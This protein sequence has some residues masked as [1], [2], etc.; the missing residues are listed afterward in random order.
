MHFA[1][2]EHY[3]YDTTTVDDWTT[4]RALLLIA[5]ELFYCKYS[6]RKLVCI[7]MWGRLFLTSALSRRLLFASFSCHEAC[8]E[9]VGERG[10]GHTDS[11]QLFHCPRRPVS[12]RTAGQ[13]QDV[14][15]EE[16][17]RADCGI[18]KRIELG[19]QRCV[20]LLGMNV[21]SYCQDFCDALGQWLLSFVSALY[22]RALHIILQHV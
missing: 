4:C 6:W 16:E 2:R 10:Q 19:E 7:I 15:A 11:R 13:D 3:Y 9:G 20:A 12:R 1:I 22:S 18:L 17:E 21:L 5:L 8:E 14:A